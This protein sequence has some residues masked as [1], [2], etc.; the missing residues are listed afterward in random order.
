MAYKSETE[1]EYNLI[2]KL[3]GQGYEWAPEV[4]SEKTLILNFRTILETRNSAQFADEPLTAKE[5]ERLM[6]QINGKS[7]FLPTRVSCGIIV[8]KIGKLNAAKATIQTIFLWREIMN[9]L[10]RRKIFKKF[11]IV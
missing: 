8:K 4:R 5:F 6:T 11:R 3:V 7:V 2:E 10:L 9:L 1:L